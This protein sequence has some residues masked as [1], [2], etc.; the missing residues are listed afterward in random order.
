MR[1]KWIALIVIVILAAFVAYNYIYQDHRDIKSE[2]AEFSMPSSEIMLQ[3]SED[4]TSAEQKYLN[5]TIE[6][7]GIISDK[8]SN[9]ITIDD[10][11]FCQF[12]ETLKSDNQINSKIK[13]KGRVIGY[14]DLLEQVKLD[15]CTII[16]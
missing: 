10:K 2:T 13:I 4:A 16:N 15:Q 7:S 1:K 11:V 9:D 6:V 3:F 5:K 8:T 14:D 12:T